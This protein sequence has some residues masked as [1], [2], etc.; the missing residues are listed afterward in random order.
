MQN[1]MKKKNRGRYSLE[2]SLWL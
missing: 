1:F 2:T